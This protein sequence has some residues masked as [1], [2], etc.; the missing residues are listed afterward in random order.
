[1]DGDF[2]KNFVLSQQRA[3]SIWER[4]VLQG[5]HRDLR[6]PRARESYRGLRRLVGGSYAGYPVNQG[7]QLADVRRL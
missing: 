7:Y 2:D 1:M 6:R 4:L 3:A 5:V